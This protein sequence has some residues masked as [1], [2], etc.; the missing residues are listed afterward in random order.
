[1][2]LISAS[3]SGTYNLL[4]FSTCLTMTFQEDVSTTVYS[5]Y[6]KLPKSG[7]PNRE[8]EWTTLASFLSCMSFS[9]N[10]DLHLVWTFLTKGC[11]R[12]I[13]SKPSRNIFL[14]L[15]L[16]N[17]PTMSPCCPRLEKRK[18]EAAMKIHVYLLCSLSNFY[19][20]YCTWS[21]VNYCLV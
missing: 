8:S 13:K 19:I 1:M 4:R 12:V 10:Y 15:W 16:I 5:Y 9:P 14:C 7:K 21:R 3:S 18:L 17:Q 11:Y 2:V 20:F 6:E